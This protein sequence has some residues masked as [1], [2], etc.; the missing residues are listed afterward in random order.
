M[1]RLWRRFNYRTACLGHDSF[2]SSVQV[3]EPDGR[4]WSARWQGF[5]GADTARRLEGARSV[6]LIVEFIE[7]DSGS[8]HGRR[9]LERD[10]YVQGCV[11]DED[12]WAIVDHRVRI[13]KGPERGP[14]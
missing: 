7:N 12:A 2:V 1:I 5:M 14:R 13:V 6:R 9:Q 8:R 4:T 10:E 3:F 11:L